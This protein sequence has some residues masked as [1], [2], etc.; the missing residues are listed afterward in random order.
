[1]SRTASISYHNK[2]PIELRLYREFN[3]SEYG[4]NIITTVLAHR[5]NDSKNDSG[6]FLFSL[7]KPIRF[8][9]T[10]CECCNR[11]KELCNNIISAMAFFNSVKIHS[12]FIQHK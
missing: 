1:M 8:D 10:M 4:D 11:F 7:I 5:S 12:R 6:Q 9:F 2:R 3:L